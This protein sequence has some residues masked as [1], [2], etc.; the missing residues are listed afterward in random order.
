MIESPVQLFQT[1]LNYVSV[2]NIIINV[3]I[4]NVKRINAIY[5]TH[6]NFKQFQDFLDEISKVMCILTIRVQFQTKLKIIIRGQEY[7]QALLY[8]QYPEL[9]T[10]SWIQF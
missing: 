6:T 8:L 3:E 10:Q 7:S 2:V 9:K 1:K 4:A 5:T